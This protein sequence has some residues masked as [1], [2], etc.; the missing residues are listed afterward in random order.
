M[1]C[2]YDRNVSVKYKG[3]YIYE[4]VDRKRNQRKSCGGKGDADK[5]DRAYRSIDPEYPR[6]FHSRNVP[7]GDSVYIGYG[8]AFPSYTRRKYTEEKKR[9][10]RQISEC[11][12]FG[13]ICGG[14]DGDNAKTY[15]SAVCV[16][17]SHLKPLFFGQAQYILNGLIDNRNIGGTAYLL[18]H[19]L[20]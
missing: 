20:R 17:H 7:D 9:G 5:H 1:I 6:H 4:I 13:D 19:T 12:I 10:L 15:H 3:E 11:C 18:L 14:A 2:K 8:N 16:P